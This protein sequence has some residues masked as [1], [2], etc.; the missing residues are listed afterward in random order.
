M[1]FQGRKM[2]LAD[3]GPQLMHPALFFR[4][5]WESF[6][7]AKSN[8]HLH[9]QVRARLLHLFCF[10][11]TK[12]TPGTL[13]RHSRPVLRFTLRK[14]VGSREEAALQRHIHL[15]VWSFLFQLQ[16]AQNR[17]SSCQ[18]KPGWSHKPN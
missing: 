6:Y 5:H 4:G 8:L 3:A 1:S 2:D 13:V 17:R 9:W 14:E 18:T 15:A 7:R 10:S 16:V 11:D 12:G